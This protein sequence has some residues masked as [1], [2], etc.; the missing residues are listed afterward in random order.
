MGV[1]TAAVVVLLAPKP[2]KN[3]FNRVLACNKM[4]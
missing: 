2:E 1:P 3:T 4:H